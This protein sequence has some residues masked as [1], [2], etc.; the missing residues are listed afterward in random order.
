MTE[1]KIKT[2]P[3][4][5][6]AIKDILRHSYKDVDEYILA[7]IEELEADNNILERN[8]YFLE[9]AVSQWAKQYDELAYKV[10]ESE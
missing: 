1:Q 8:K 3:E 2:Y 6:E 5:N 9:K 10:G 7:R 4:M